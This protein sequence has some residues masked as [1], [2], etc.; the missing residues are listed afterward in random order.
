MINKPVKGTHGDITNG[1][2]MYGVIFSHY[3]YNLTVFVVSIEID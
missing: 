3:I 1:Y 2:T